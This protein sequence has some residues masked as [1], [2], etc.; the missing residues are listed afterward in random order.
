MGGGGFPQQ[1][2]LTSELG[3]LLAED[4]ERQSKI[5]VPGMFR[6]FT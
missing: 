4:G 5:R 3:T 6:N 1:L 2:K